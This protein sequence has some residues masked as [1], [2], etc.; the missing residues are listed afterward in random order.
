MEVLLNIV[1]VYE[2]GRVYQKDVLGLST[3]YTQMLPQAFNNALNLSMFVVF[4]TKENI[5][6]L[7][8]KASQ[9]ANAVNGLVGAWKRKSESAKEAETANGGTKNETKNEQK[10]LKEETQE[11][12]ETKDKPIEHGGEG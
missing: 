6:Y 3:K 9:A 7:L 11:T 8:A 2:G 1:A 10:E 4:P 12:K 5:K